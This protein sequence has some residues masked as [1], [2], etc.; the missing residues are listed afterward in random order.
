VE[1]EVLPDRQAPIERVRLGDHA[2]PRLGGRWV[3]DDVDAGHD[4]RA[5]RGDHARRQHPDGGGLAGAVRA[6][7]AEDL[8]RSDLQVERVDGFDAVV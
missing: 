2:D 4:R 6:E 5:R 7:E 8:A 1:I 3:R